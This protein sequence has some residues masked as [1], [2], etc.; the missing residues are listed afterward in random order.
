MYLVHDTKFYE[1]S[2]IK[3]AIYIHYGKIPDMSSQLPFGTLKKYTLENSVKRK[4]FYNNK[5]NEKLKKGYKM[6][7]NGTGASYDM[8][9][10]IKIKNL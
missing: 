6:V 9:K 3:G 7:K 4:S 2:W 8:K 10:M 1:I 5:I